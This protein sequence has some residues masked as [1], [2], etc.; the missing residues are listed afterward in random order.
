[1]IDERTEELAAAYVLGALEAGELT[2]FEAQ[3][4]EGAELRGLVTEL[5]AVSALLA[6]TAPSLQ[7]PAALRATL[8]ADLGQRQAPLEPSSLA[9][10]AFARRSTAPWLPWALAAGF[11]ALCAFFGWQ[12]NGL[13]VQL[14]AQQRR[15]QELTALADT[16]RAE[17]GDLRQ[18]VLKLQQSNRL[19]N[20]RIAVLN[21]QLKSEPQALAVSVWD[22]E[23]QD[24]IVV[25]HHLK[26]PSKDKD[27]QLW[28]IDPRYPSPVDAGVMHVDD[29]GD[30]RVEFKARQ[31]IQNASQFAVTEEV[32]GGAAAPTL[33]AMVLAGA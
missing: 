15:V 2:L 29:A 31:P 8:L 13:R 23:R 33:K 10:P 3:L 26:P 9:R 6:G 30:G 1:V 32:K 16:L 12:A 5:R 19:A 4:R 14:D 27:Y 22:N 18:A 28:I 21:S 24:G 25:V 20:M 17:R 11:A 7:P